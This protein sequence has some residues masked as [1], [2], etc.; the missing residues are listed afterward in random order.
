MLEITDLHVSYGRVEAV[1]GFEATVRPGRITLV[2]GANGAGKTTSLCAIAGMRRMVKGSVSFKGAEMLGKAAHRI[3]AAGITLVPEGRK[4]FAP[5]SVEENLL[6]GGHTA[7]RAAV[8][9]NLD[10]VF[11]MF[12]VLK[13]RRSSAGGLLSGGEQ[14]ML[15]FGRALMS[16]PQAVLLDEPSMGLAPIVVDQVLESVR[17]IADS[18]IGVLMVEQHADASLAI[19]D[20]VVILARGEVV[21]S[22]SAGSV[23]S[24]A[25]VVRAFLGDAALHEP[26]RE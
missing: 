10:R 14:Q 5:L 6:V 21:H 20:D 25:S 8:V 15:A 7:S 17:A 26:A 16:D 3:V 19:A 9:E 22:G 18:G 12:P 24:R 23:S 4:I 11:T 2:L 13:E 1:R